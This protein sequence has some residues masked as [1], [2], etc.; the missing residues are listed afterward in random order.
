[1][2]DEQIHQPTIQRNTKRKLCHI[3][4]CLSYW[5]STLV[6][7]HQRPPHRTKLVRLW[8]LLVHLDLALTI[9]VH[10]VAL[11]KLLSSNFQF[12]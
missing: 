4:K 8:I 2:F 5:G 3:A 7:E 12:F 1:M 6:S 11:G 9:M 10:S